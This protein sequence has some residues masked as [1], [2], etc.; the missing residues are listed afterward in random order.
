[1]SQN[2][3][4]HDPLTRSSYPRKQPL[5]KRQYGF[6]H[7]ITPTTWID[8]E[9]CVHYKWTNEDDWWIASHIPQLID[10]LDC[11][12][13]VDIVFTVRVFMYLY[14][15]LFKGP[16]HTQFRL[17]QNEETGVNKITDYINGRY[18]SAPEAAWRILNFEIV[19]KQPSVSCLPVH[20]PSQNTPQFL[21]GSSN[22]SST[23]LLTWYLHRPLHPTFHS[24]TYSQYFSSYVDEPG[25]LVWLDT[26]PF[27]HF[28]ISAPTLIDHDAR[29]WCD[30]SRELHEPT[31]SR[32][33]SMLDFH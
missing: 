5:L 30:A 23:S 25:I 18:L 7:P 33:R 2:S 28:S 17:L 14:K 24:L 19:H 9:G 22:V 12:I 4:I 6:P 15:Y 29:N 26:L 16:D 27:S 3:E 10:E 21:Q 31:R 20:L 11:H 8:E 13:H 32:A 1:M